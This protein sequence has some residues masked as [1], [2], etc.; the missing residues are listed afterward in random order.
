M[1]SNG[2]ARGR[3]LRT[4]A[5]RELFHDIPGMTRLGWSIIRGATGGPPTGGTMSSSKTEALTTESTADPAPAARDPRAAMPAPGGARRGPTWD[6]VLARDDKDKDG[7]VS[8][9]EFSGPKELFDRLDANHDGF[10]TREEHEAFIAKMQGARA[11]TSP[12]QK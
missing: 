11:Q 8:R 12:P 3:R 7:K 9:E 5:V 10:L 1:S 2:P 6:A 4:T